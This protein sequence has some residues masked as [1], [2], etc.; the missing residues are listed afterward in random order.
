V[1]LRLWIQKSEEVGMLMY[2]SITIT[3]HLD[4]RWSEWFDGLTITNLENG[5]TV[6]AGYLSDQAALHG[7][8]TKVRDLGLPLISVQ[9]EGE[10]AYPVARGDARRPSRTSRRRQPAVVKSVEPVGMDTR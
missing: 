6:L 10:G 8:L 1:S 5:E 9:C 4:A 3:G 7:A 2:C